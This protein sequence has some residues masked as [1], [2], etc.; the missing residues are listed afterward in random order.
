[1]NMYRIFFIAAS[2]LCLITNCSKEEENKEPPI[3]SQ[4]QKSKEKE[5]QKEKDEDVQK[6]E[7][8][9]K[10]SVSYGRFTDRENTTYRDANNNLVTVT[11]LI[12]IVVGPVDN[13]FE[14][15]VAGTA[16]SAFYSST[17]KIEVSK[18]GGVFM[19]KA[20]KRGVSSLTYKIDF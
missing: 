10:Y 13:S 4:Q 6:D 20:Y 18:N 7:Y 5:E 19:T 9:V 2:F 17:K 3:A 14:A 11:G 15:Y 12:E 8:F 1:M 16:G